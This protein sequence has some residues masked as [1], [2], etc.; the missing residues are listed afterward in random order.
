MWLSFVSLWF[1][2]VLL[3]WH[4]SC[5]LVVPQVTANLALLWWALCFMR[6]YYVALLSRACGCTRCCWPRE[7]LQISE[8][9]HFVKS[10]IPRIN[11]ISRVEHSLAYFSWIPG[12]TQYAVSQIKHFS[13]L[14]F[15]CKLMLTRKFENLL[16]ETGLR[17]FFFNQCYRTIPNQQA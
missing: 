2:K 10:S 14:F 1:L 9:V 7:T 12:F 11:F 4:A 17:G 13:R 3:M 15:F 6:F 8:R 5:E 16:L